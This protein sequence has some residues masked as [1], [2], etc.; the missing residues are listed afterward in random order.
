MNSDGKQDLILG[1]IGENF[2]LR[3]DAKKPAKLWLNDFDQNGTTEQFITR[4]IDGKD[5]PVFLK[6]EITDQF[7]GLKKQNLKHSD[8]ATKTIQDLFGKEVIAK[9]TVKEFNYCQSVVAINNGHGGFT[10]QPLPVMV[11]LSSVNAVYA[12]DLNSDGKTDLVLGGNMFGFPPQFGRLDGSYGHVLLNNGKGG[13][14][15]IKPGESGISLRGEIKD[16][17]EIAVKGKRCLL[18]VQNDET[19]V[20]YQVKK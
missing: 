3:P 13:F 14:N 11:Q 19:P 20:M 1:N 5:M 2:Y 15:W 7:P 18:V 8:Y 6:R 10:I 9:A 4:M 12:T 16:I 17:K